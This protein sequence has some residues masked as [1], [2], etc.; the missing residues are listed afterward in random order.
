MLVCI[1]LLEFVLLLV[2]TFFISKITGKV[3][4]KILLLPL[5]GVAAIL[6]GQFSSLYSTGRYTEVMTLSNLKSYR[7]VGGGILFSSLLITFCCIILCLLVA[8]KS[9]KFQ[10]KRKW[11]AI[12]VIICSVLIIDL[13]HQGAV[14]SFVRAYR[15]YLK[16]DFFMPDKE[17]LKVQQR[18]YAQDLTYDNDFDASALLDL[19]GKNIV[20][21]FA[22][23]LSVE[24]I[25]KFNK[26]FDLT[27]NLDKFIDNSVYFKNY[28]NHTAPTFRGLRGQLTSSYF[29]YG[30]SHYQNN[31]MGQISEKQIRDKLAEN[32]ISVPHILKDYDYHPYFFCTH[33]TKHDQNKVLETLEF[34][35]VYGGDEFIKGVHELTDQQQFTVLKDLILKHELNKP[36]F[37]GVYNIGTH[38]GRD[39]PDVKYQSGDNILLNTIRNFDD[40]FGKFWAAVKDQKDLAVILTADHAQCP[41][42]LYNETFG[43]HREYWVD[44]VPFAV[45]YS[46]VKPSVIDANGRNSLDFAPTLLQAMGIKKAFNYFL[47]CSLFNTECSKNFEHVSNYD[48]IFLRTPGVKGLNPNDPNDKAVIKKIQDS[49]NLSESM[50]LVP[51]NFRP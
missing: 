17:M 32:L 46:G 43:T 35:K 22:E 44:K 49:Y 28:Y 3:L 27:P 11:I 33:E 30:G 48:N 34:D 21:V 1:T 23:G 14:R 13:N 18:I 24:C 41:S 6:G 2:C 7:D 4:N 50:S 37:L 19:K 10:L 29:R 25:D 26:Y 9:N 12:P 15:E 36:F 40:A 51:P 31:V 39:S 38:I 42:E 47:G 45:W 5:L 20:V 16:Q 8:I